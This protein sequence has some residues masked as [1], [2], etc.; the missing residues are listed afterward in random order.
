QG[1]PQT[2]HHGARKDGAAP[3]GPVGA[4]HVYDCAQDGT[5]LEGGDDAS[6]DCVG[7][8]VEVGDEG[9]EGDGGGDDARVVAEEEAS[10]GEEDAGEDCG[11]AAHGGGGALRGT[12]AVRGLVESAGTGSWETSCRAEGEVAD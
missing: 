9:G 10:Q 3:A 12:L 6:R 11:L 2:R 4:E 1:G 7:G 5:A 8:L